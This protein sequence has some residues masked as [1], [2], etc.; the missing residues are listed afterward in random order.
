[1][2]S[3][4][5]TWAA[6]L[7]RGRRAEIGVAVELIDGHWRVVTGGRGRREFHALVPACPCSLVVC[8]LTH[9]NYSGQHRMNYCHRTSS[10]WHL[11]H[12]AVYVGQVLASYGCHGVRR[13][14]MLR[15]PSV[16]A[17]IGRVAA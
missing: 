5:P 15:V 13:P 11:E 8:S 2:V 7:P 3:H 16:D 14:T 9:Q 17:A 10:R 1:M 12:V 4:P 6:R